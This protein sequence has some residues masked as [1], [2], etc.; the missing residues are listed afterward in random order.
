MNGNSVKRVDSVTYLGLIIDE[1]LSWDKHVQS[2]CS[3]LTRNFHLFYNLRNLLPNHLKRQ[4]YY[5]LVYSRVQYGIEVYGS[6]S[7]NR[8]KRIQTM[9]NKLLKVLFKRPLRTSTNELHS[10][11]KLLKVKDIFK[12][13]ILKFVFNAVKKRSIKQFHN[14]YQS[15]RYTHNHDT[16]QKHLLS[17]KRPKTAHGDNMIVQTGAILWNSLDP[18]IHMTKSINIFKKSVTNYFLSNYHN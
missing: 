2:L 12:M 11:Y 3:K 13:N 7:K 1:H 17:V 8:I 14:F 5:A 6:C 16:R 15:R 18:T 10:D 4:L 9:Q